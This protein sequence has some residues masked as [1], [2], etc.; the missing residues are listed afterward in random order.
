MWLYSILDYE[1]GHYRRYTRAELSAKLEAA[2]FAVVEAK[3][4][5]LPGALGWYLA[6]V[7]LKRR[8]YSPLSFRVYN[9]LAPSFRRLESLLTPPFGLSVLC[10][11]KKLADPHAP[12]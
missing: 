1:V 12:A 8:I 3:Y 2:G 9:F 7:L 6:H 4:V 10:V 11:G 5:N